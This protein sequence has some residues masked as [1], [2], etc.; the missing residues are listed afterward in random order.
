MKKILALILILHS[1]TSYAVSKQAE[2]KSLPPMGED[3]RGAMR[4]IFSTIPDSIMPLLTR[5]NRL[6][7]IDFIENNMQARVKNRLDEWVELK[8]L[9]PDYLLLKMSERS[10][11]EMKLLSDSLICMV[12]TYKGPAEDSH[13][14]LYNQR[15]ER[16]ESPLTQ[17]P[18]VEDFFLE[19][20]DAEASGWLRAM[21]LMKASLSPT[22][23]T[24]TWELQTTELFTEQ[25]KTAQQYLQTVVKELK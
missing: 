12:R 20:L 8:Q 9:T 21:P 3:G 11:V 19:G 23:S 5:N 15:W 24:I 18:Q 7:C 4:S 2:T 17:R 1:V 16:I 10:T 25:K 22:A 6:D 14:C 13:V